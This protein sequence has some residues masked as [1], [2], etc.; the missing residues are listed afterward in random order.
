LGL[1][2]KLFG[3]K[4]SAT[5]ERPSTPAPSEAPDNSAV[6][7][8][9]PPSRPTSAAPSRSAPS[10]PTQALPIGL[11][12]MMSA[13]ESAAIG[14]DADVAGEGDDLDATPVLASADALS[15]SDSDPIAPQIAPS[16]PT[17]AAPDASE[18][19]V[20]EKPT[21]DPSSES[22]EDGSESSEEEDE[23]EVG[24][25]N[26]DWRLGGFSNKGRSKWEPKTGMEARSERQGEATF[27]RGADYSGEEIDYMTGAKAGLGVAERTKFYN[28]EERDAHEL[29]AS[30]GRLM[31]AS[32]EAMDTS[33]AAATQLKGGDKGRN[34]FAMTPDVQKGSR[35]FAADAAKETNDSMERA[36]ASKRDG[37]DEAFEHVHHSSFS[38]GRDVSAA[39]D[40]DVKDGWVKKISNNSGHYTPDDRSNIQ[41]FEG[42]EAMGANLDAAKIESFAN[43]GDVNGEKKSYMARPFAASGGDTDLLDAQASMFS[44]IQ[45]AS[46]PS[47]I[48]NNKGNVRRPRAARKVGAS[49]SEPLTAELELMPADQMEVVRGPED[50]AAPTQD[51]AQVPAEVVPEAPVST[52]QASSYA[53]FP[54]AKPETSYAPLG[55][56]AAGSDTSSEESSAESSSEESSSGASTSYVPSGTLTG[57]MN[58]TS[59]YAA[60]NGS[61][62]AAANYGL[63][64]SDDDEHVLLSE[65]ESE[66]DDD[67][68][69]PDDRTEK[70]AGPW[71]R[72]VRNNPNGRAHWGAAG[73]NKLGGPRSAD[74][75]PKAFRASNE[76]SGENQSYFNPDKSLPAGVHERTK[77]FDDQER[78]AHQVGVKDGLLTNAQGEKLDTTSASSTNLAG[79][80][81]QRNIFAIDHDAKH[82]QRMFS[83]DAAKEGEDSKNRA[84]AEHSARGA[85]ASARQDL[86][87]RRENPEVAA[88]IEAGETSDIDDLLPAIDAEPESAKSTVE[89]VHHS[90]FT[91]GQALDAAGDMQVKEGYL[92]KISNASGHYTPDDTSNLQALQ[93]LDAMGA[94]LDATTVEH[95][96]RDGRDFKRTNYQAR[97]VLATGN[98]RPLMDAHKQTFEGIRAGKTLKE[99]PVDAEL[100]AKKQQERAWTPEELAEKKRLESEGA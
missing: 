76:F 81:A 15:R 75:E 87:A 99:R 39:G 27:A 29:H 55:T 65:S 52:A 72:D 54:V 48:K 50:A 74:A 94:N 32:G 45:W 86:E 92:Q 44:D 98:D 41:A 11:T 22:A 73:E 68:D 66:E 25:T 21:W 34:I 2:K 80:D 13:P 12:P 100:E 3:K 16:L 71:K 24:D 96:E 35:A 56:L 37:G 42:L 14:H 40:I 69:F 58:D 31:R 8:T 91:G 33:G 23:R 79:T 46:K 7:Q 83:S 62:Y 89:R 10:R 26:G 67:L 5:P 1:A 20:E 51:Q 18:S 17:W 9:M 4:K 70:L 36:K 61:H 59:H 64:E 84:L 93:A 53:A 47:D 60:A 97:A 38:N 57:G 30:E 78:D 63:S 77:Y 88:R 90:S 82:G 6:L 43:V 85:A 95:G 19:S 28:D 49:P